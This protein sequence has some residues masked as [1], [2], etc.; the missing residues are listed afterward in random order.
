MAIELK[1][2]TNGQEVAL[3]LRIRDAEGDIADL[4]VA[5]L[6]EMIDVLASHTAGLPEGWSDATLPQRAQWLLRWMARAT[7]AQYRS[8]HL[9]DLQRAAQN[10]LGDIE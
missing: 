2:A 9:R 3:P 8:F 10:N 1:L 6:E 5:Q 4:T 7:Y